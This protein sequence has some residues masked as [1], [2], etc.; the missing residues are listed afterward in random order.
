MGPGL[1]IARLLLFLFRNGSGGFLAPPSRFEGVKTYDST[2][3][4]SRGGK[5][6]RFVYGAF[7]RPFS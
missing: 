4:E 7:Y 5:N 2:N 1:E 6:G 3:L